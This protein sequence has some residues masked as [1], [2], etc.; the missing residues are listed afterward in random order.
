MKRNYLILAFV[1]GI[2]AVLFGVISGQLILMTIV[3]ILIALALVGSDMVQWV[4]TRI[5]LHIE[6]ERSVTDM[7]HPEE[8]LGSVNHDMSEIKQRLDNMDHRDL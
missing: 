5:E 2:I 6:N 8:S 7:H 3:V 4:R 1:L